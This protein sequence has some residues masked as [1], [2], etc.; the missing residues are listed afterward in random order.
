M[1]GVESKGLIG[2]CLADA[3][4]GNV[5]RFVGVIGVLPILVLRLFLTWSMLIIPKYPATPAVR[6]D[7]PDEVKFAIVRKIADRFK[8]DHEVIDVDSA[9]VQFPGGWGL[10]RAS[11]TQPALVI[12]AEATTSDGLLRIKKAI[13]SE[14]RKFPE[15][16]P[17][18]W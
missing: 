4:Q 12:R 2:R 1:W 10:V 17:I 13:E 16:G 18:S 8:Q 5:R 11:N 14:L 9:R 6:V 15:V 3:W 7:C